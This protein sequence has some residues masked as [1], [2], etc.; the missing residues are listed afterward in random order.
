MKIIE[1]QADA[2]ARVVSGQSE[3]VVV[4][5]DQDGI[6]EL[7]VTMLIQHNAVASEVT[8][9]HVAEEEFPKWPTGTQC[10]WAL[11]AWRARLRRMRWLFVSGI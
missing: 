2:S 5:T 7:A 1:Y 10:G 3:D 8:A 6:G 4:I 11:L 9:A